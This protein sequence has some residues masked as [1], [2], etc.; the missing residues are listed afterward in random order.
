MALENL[1]ENISYV[2]ITDF[3]QV[4]ADGFR[5]SKEDYNSYLSEDER[6]DEFLKLGLIITSKDEEIG[7][8]AGKILGS[9]LQ[10]SCRKM[11]YDIV[12]KII[13]NENLDA[14]LV[15]FYGDDGHFRFSFIKVNYLGQKRNFT[16]YKRYS[17]YIEPEKAN[18]TFRQQITKTDYSSESNILKAFS[19]EEISSDFYNEFKPHY[20]SLVSH[21]ISENEIAQK[22]REEFALLFVI[23]LIF[24]GFVQKRGWLGEKKEFIQEFWHEYRKYRA[25]SDIHD[26]FYSRW[27]EPLFFDAF[28]H[29][30]GRKVHYGANNFSK[31]TEEILQMAP[32]L[33]GGLFEMRK[34]IDDKDYYLP[35]DD[36][37]EFIN[38]LFQY[39]FTVEENT[40]YDEELE[41][42]PEFLG[43]IFEKLINKE[44][45]AIYTP[46]TEV[47]LMCRLAISKWLEK[48][49]VI[50]KKK[51]YVL[52][53][54]VE[55]ERAEIELTTEN[56]RNIHSML[57]HV[58]VCDP[59]AGS[60]AFEV[61][62]L[63]VIDELME[64]ISELPRAPLEI[65]ESDRYLRKRKIISRSL[66]GVEVKQWAVWINQLR[67]W[68]TLFIE[69][70]DADRF[71]TKP[72]LPSLNFKV[73]QG[74]SLVQMI[75]NKLFPFQEIRVNSSYLKKK[76]N[77]LIEKKAEYFENQR[78][79]LNLIR[80]EE[81]L[82]L[83]SIINEEIDEIRD[84][85]Q[86]KQKKL[87]N[88]S[89]EKQV[90]QQDLF[91]DG[92]SIQESININK[93]VILDINEEIK[94]LEG[95]IKE[96]EGEQENIEHNEYFIWNI[97]FAEI[98]SEKGGFDIIIGNPP[99][100]RQE[101]IEDPLG[102]M[103]KS[104]YK[105]M[106]QEVIYNDYIGYFRNIRGEQIKKIDKKSDLY[107][108]FYLHT[109]N[110]L[111]TGGVHCFICSNSWLDV[112]YGAW[113]QEFILNKVKLHL[114]IDNQVKRSFVSADIN[115]VITLMDKPVQRF[116]GNNEIRFVGFRKPF[117]NVISAENME[118]ITGT[119]EKVFEEKQR[120]VVKSYQGLRS[121]GTLDGKYKGDKWGG[122]FLRAPEIFYTILE[123]GKD[124]LVRLGDIAEVRFGIK[125]GCNEFFYLS[126]TVADE[127]NIDD[128]F[129]NPCI[130]SIRGVNR[131]LTSK[132]D[133]MKL[134]CIPQNAELLSYHSLNKYISYGISME[135]NKRSTCRNRKK[136]FSL[137]NWKIAPIIVPVNIGE[138]FIVLLNDA[139]I[140]QL[141]QFY[142]IYIDQ[143]N[144]KQI[145]LYL[146]S[147]ITLLFLQLS[148]WQLTGAQ[149]ILHFS[150][151]D[152][153]S[154]KVCIPDT[155]PQKALNIIKRRN[156]K[157]IFIE[158]GITPEN[159]IPI[160]EQEPN[161][162]PDRKELDDIVFDALSLTEEERKDV[163]RAVC[164]LV[165]DRL[166]KARSLNR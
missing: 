97:E 73:C 80:Q 83:K 16:T 137:Q 86:N 55:E 151:S 63:Q 71:S 87:I 26:E 74:D 13:K 32:Y 7:V 130:G 88:Y 115:T 127:K 31:E 106:L 161:P 131:V 94:E 40:R 116:G 162:L 96:L 99:Y 150:V 118:H 135:Y 19:I 47:D 37:E 25:K 22:A 165:W 30:P 125:T 72:L 49:V 48:N 138:R 141:D 59:A 157:N 3:F 114:V 15:V 6:F 62:M 68:L 81:K 149:A 50:E 21:V 91:D 145:V 43:I 17:F 105:T 152:L 42:N 20:E 54:G 140:Y 119:S 117:E 158:C 36:I 85:I 61:G 147:I 76:I 121:E 100:L 109:L 84:D 124:N 35:D 144:L 136:W 8:F 70:P 24:L 102:R 28:C 23:R 2:T 126:Q 58:Q 134:L 12:K 159:G 143:S 154:I 79:D 75:G 77:N 44:M 132:V 93:Q 133:T 98:F 156:A 29:A 1:I 166:S 33:N 52:I 112:G 66:Y 101:K 139:E 111:N 129:F 103:D 46:R 57:S 41:L 107:T 89:E 45:G 5:E 60:G 39:N 90:A 69:M 67:L 153:S 53:F 9:I 14:A 146:N 11:Q 123:K 65:K 56:I 128:K 164:R 51:L 82:I 104:V 160:E 148:G 4:K 120:I 27:L 38:F 92:M 64:F 142:G 110:L 108:Y 113:M 163:Y 78:H 155:D 34:G 122:K 10:R 95:K 18:K